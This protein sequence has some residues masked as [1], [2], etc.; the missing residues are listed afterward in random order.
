[1]YF[2]PDDLSR[3]GPIEERLLFETGLISEERCLKGSSIRQPGEPVRKNITR[4]QQ[5]SNEGR[6]ACIYE[7][8]GNCSI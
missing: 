1:M 2:P 3:G 4:I 7:T 6:P 5:A 8:T